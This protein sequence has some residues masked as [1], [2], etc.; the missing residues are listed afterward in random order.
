MTTV[1]RTRQRAEE[2]AALLDG[3]HPV[4]AARSAEVER[5][6]GLARALRAQ[7]AADLTAD[8]S[9]PRDDF[10]AELR[11]RL[12]AEAVTVLRP[13]AKPLA[14]PV[15][16][17]GPRERRLVAAASVAVLLGG[18]AGMASAARSALPGE[19]LYPLKRGIESAEVRLSLSD[20]GRGRDL[21][22]QA[23]GRLTEARGLLAGDAAAPAVQ[24]PA[25]LDDFTAQAREGADLLLASYGADHDP[26]SVSEVRSFAASGLRLVE[27]MA[28]SAPSE[29]Q[30][31][32]R[33]AA[34]VL[35]DIDR[36]AE[37]LCGDCTDL[38]SLALPG[39]FRASYE[40]D[41]ARV[42]LQ[43][44]RLREHPLDN[45]HPVVVDGSEVRRGR[46]TGPGAVA[47]G[48]ALSPSQ[49]TAGAGT[50]PSAPSAPTT[51]GAPA[52]GTEDLP[53]TTPPKVELRLPVSPPV[54]PLGSG[55][56]AGPVTGLGKGLGDGLGAGLGGPV[57]ML[58]DPPVSP[59]LDQDLDTPLP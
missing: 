45:S 27:G 38:P 51:P 50:D 56:G 54:S 58:P 29:V 26:A 8:R 42:R 7:G 16:K 36:A 43:D 37:R 46:S 11:E 41:R 23:D 5:L 12:M 47:G 9:V 49:D 25:T 53:G 35:Q 10:A 48:Q 18:T 39:A 44:P 15:R 55:P 1:F 14:L 57:T 30:P 40:V 3:A 17:R 22:E 4:R 52:G 19:A 20:A 28:G 21:L 2:L 34:L 32:L 33:A 13:G 31:A 24:V 6:V 59:P